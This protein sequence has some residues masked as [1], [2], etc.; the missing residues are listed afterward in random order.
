[1]ADYVL[2][3]KSRNIASNMV[4]ILLNILLGVGSV[5]ITVLSGSPLLGLLLVLI[6]KWRVFAVRARYF[7]INL[8]S[9]LVDMIV[10]ASVV[11]LAYYAGP[12]FL[13]VDFILATFYVVWLI[14]IK[15]L[16]SERALLVQSLIAVFLGISAATILSANLNS[17]VITA[18]AFL[19]GYA[20]SRHILVQTSDKDFTLTT[21]VCGLIFAEITWLCHSW[22]II[23]T[24]G[25]TGVR[26]PQV[27][28]ILTIFAFV[29][30]YA[31]QAMIKYQDDFKFKHILGPVA[32][33]VILV[34][35]IVI[36][37]SKPIFNI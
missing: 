14:F 9:N 12:S 10:G 33:G 35:I 4:H 22:S 24:F 26:I 18:L 1:M 30:N 8:K 7:A 15:P 32:F 27:A 28:I 37:F 5:L 20:A 23:Y 29:Y 13:P 21:L 31:R 6:S 11:L 16:S 19:I 36:F 17:I 2:V 3:R 34:G 25:T